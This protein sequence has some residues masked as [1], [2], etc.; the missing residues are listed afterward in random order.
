MNLT[1]DQLVKIYMFC[2]GVPYYLTYIKKGKSA[3]QLI[4]KM[5]FQEDGVLYNEFDKLFDSLFEEA[6][7]YKGIIKTIAKKREGIPRSQIEEIAFLT[8]GG[9][10]T[11]RLK[12]LEDAAFVKA[13]L[14]LNHKRQGIY[15][16]VMDEYCYFY[17]KWIESAKKTLIIQEK[18][19]KYWSNKTN[20]SEYYSWMGYVFESICYKHV[21][22]IR[23]ALD[24]TPGC[25]VGV[26][27]YTPRKGSKEE[28]A[29][30]D[31]VFEH[32][33]H[34]T[35]LCEIKYTDKAFSIDK[36]YAENLKRKIRVYKERTRTK[37]QIYL[38]LISANGLKENSHSDELIHGVVTLDDLFRG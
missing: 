17:L 7:I 14:P 16:R 20:S 30:I 31:L 9:T 4:D 29:Q 37:N 15:Y 11:E 38:V 10:L 27:Q 19:S 8:K 21:R 13:F 33:D 5:C 3:A 22:E 18:N 24:I 32:G 35:T 12:D 1:P 23:I 25:T 36:E 26:W 34:V 2:G 28:G 6:E